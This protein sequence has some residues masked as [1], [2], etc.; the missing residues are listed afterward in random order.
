MVLAHPEC[1]VPVVLEH[2]SDRGA[3]CGQPPGGAGIPIRSLGDRGEA[4]HVV[5]AAGKQA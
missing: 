4:I 3:L 1:A 2:L 5:V